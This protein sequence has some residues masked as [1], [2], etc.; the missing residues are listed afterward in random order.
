MDVPHVLVMFGLGNAGSEVDGVPN[1]ILCLAAKEAIR[2][3]A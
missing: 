2:G 1:V 3:D